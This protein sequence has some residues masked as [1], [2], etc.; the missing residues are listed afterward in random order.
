MSKMLDGKVAIVTGAGNGI[1]RA[2]AMELA[3]HGASVIVNDVSSHPSS[4]SGSRTVDI[5]RD[6]GGRA[7]PHFGDVGDERSVAELIDAAVEEFGGLDILVNNAGIVRDRSL[8]KMTA[9]DFDEVIR[10]HLRGTWLGCHFAAKYWE[11][12]R[13]SATSRNGT[14]INT[15]SGAGLEGNFGQSNYAAAKA[16]IVGLT[17]TLSL[18]LARFG[19]TVNAICP[20]GATQLSSQ[21][22][23]MPAPIEPD[24]VPEDVFLEHDPSLGSPMVAWLASDHAAHVSGQVLNVYGGQIELLEGWR[25]RAVI[26]SGGKRWQAESLGALVESDLFA[27]RWRGPRW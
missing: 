6:H 25:S 27:T 3:K 9:D 26:N 1:G 13:A 17:L 8:T 7:S 10:V 12:R 24:L 20:G 22:P 16:G 18:E 5:I 4:S 11:A 14:I 2:H 19:V 21:M 23:G 15:S